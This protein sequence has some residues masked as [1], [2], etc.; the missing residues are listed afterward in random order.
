MKSSTLIIYLLNNRFENSELY[1]DEI[2]N[3]FSY[4]QDD[5]LNTSLNSTKSK[6]RQSFRGSIGSVTEVEQNLKKF[7]NTVKSKSFNLKIQEEE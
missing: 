5:S 2:N 3:Q 7:Q 4:F 6:D 1:S